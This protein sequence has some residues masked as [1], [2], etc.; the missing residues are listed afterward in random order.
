MNK[1]MARAKRD[2][3]PPSTAGTS[4]GRARFWTVAVSVMAI[5]LVAAIAQVASAEPIADAVSTTA[6]VATTVTVPEAREARPARAVAQKPE[7]TVFSELGDVTLVSGATASNAA[8]SVDAT[9]PPPPPTTTTTTTTTAP[10]APAPAPAPVAEQ[11]TGRCGG[12]LPPCYVMMR[13]SGGNIRAQ[14]PSSSASGKWQF[15]SSTWAGYG[16]YAE[17]YLAPE[18]VQDAK[19]R[20]LWAGGAGC[21]HWN[22]C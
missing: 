22:A 15:I 17:A 7:T 8:A 10:P 6:K 1:E 18:S 5:G 9:P 20:E 4:A 12:D 21:G 16:G 3:Q 2:E 19:A 14:N 13:E 11:G